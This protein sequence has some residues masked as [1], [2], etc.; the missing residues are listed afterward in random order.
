MIRLDDLM[1]FVRTAALG[2]FS[3]AAREADL[4]PGQVS[5]AIQR[6]ER[7]LDVRLFARST[8]SLRLTA[9]GDQYL[10]YAEEV[11][12]TLREGGERLRGEAHALQ[13]LLQIAAPSD[14]GRNVLLP[15]ITAFREAHPRLSVRLFLSDQ[16][17]DVFRDPVDIAIRYG[18]ADEASYVALPLVDNRRVLVASP[19][20]LGRHG[21][22]QALEDLKRHRCLL[23]ERAGRVYDKWVFPAD[24]ARRVVAVAGSLFCDDA[25]VI[26]RW[27]VDGQGVAY[28][29]WLDVCADVRAGR[30][31]VLLP[32]QLGELTPLNL[33]CPHRK[34]FWPAT[35]ALHAVLREKL[36]AL[37]SDAPAARG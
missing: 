31:E 33:I 18:V 4:L 19:A 25:D 3:N 1:L 9:E 22:P 17:A 35:R 16:L 24:G 37:A 36:A 5:A 11:L 6:L 12:A 28:K 34:Q 2:S 21:R 13:G 26:R 27:A 23:Y 7:E 14:L 10:P 29:S 30:L 20:Y 8:R 15:W 32:E